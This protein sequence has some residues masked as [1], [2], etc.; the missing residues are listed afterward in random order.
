MQIIKVSLLLGMMLFSHLFLH[1]VLF[2]PHLVCTRVGVFGT[3]SFSFGFIS[4]GFKRTIFNNSSNFW[5]F[6]LHLWS[7][8]I[9]I[10]SVHGDKTSFKTYLS[11]LKENKC[12]Q[13]EFLSFG[14]I[15][16][17]YKAH[18]HHSLCIYYCKYSFSSSFKCY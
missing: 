4:F 13:G 11:N 6:Y 8:L 14:I 15:M 5:H 10:S 12:V 7:C 16:L 1:L 2:F 17:V 18:V 9:A 3:V